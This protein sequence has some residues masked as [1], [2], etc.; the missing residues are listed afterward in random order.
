[1]AQK[2]KISANQI[3]KDVKNGLDDEALMEKYSLSEDNLNK[4]LQKLIHAGAITQEELDSRQD[5]FEL[6]MDFDKRQSTGKVNATISAA[7]GVIKKE[8]ADFK[9]EITDEI[10]SRKSSVN[11]DGNNVESET[12]QEQRVEA[13]QSFST[14]SLD[15]HYR[16][17][18]YKLEKSSK[19]AYQRMN[20]WVILLGFLWYF[21]KGMWQKALIYFAVVSAIS[22]VATLIAG[23]GSG[24]L[25]L[26]FFLVLANIA[27]YDYYLYSVHGETSFSRNWLSLVM[28]RFPENLPRKIYVAGSQPNSSEKWDS[29]EEVK[30]LGGR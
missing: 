4:V 25:A 18:F 14:L 13:K 9:K 2:R 7:K 3:V 21:Y 6:D 16:D 1:M 11:K 26:L 28:G 10:S 27:N 15:P 30:A 23:Y 12:Y 22:A 19:P 17:I 8:V 24:G 20:G 29:S 5:D